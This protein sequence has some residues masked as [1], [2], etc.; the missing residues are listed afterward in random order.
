MKKA[1]KDIEKYILSQEEQGRVV[2]MTI[3]GFAEASLEDII[4]QPT[5]GLL[6]DLNRDRATILTFIEDKKWVND[7]ACMLVIIKLKQKLTEHDN[8]IK[9]LID[10]MI[11][12]AKKDMDSISIG[13]VL[14]LTQ[15][16]NKAGL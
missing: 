15:L 16:K 7:F 11:E 5:E 4:K 10:K 9:E 2:I 6:Y 3:E 13:R 14:A 1:F 12:E 8:E